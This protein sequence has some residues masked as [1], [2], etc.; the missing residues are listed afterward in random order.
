ME[1]N[2]DEENL[3]EPKIEKEEPTDPTLSKLIIFLIS[4]AIAIV[5][6]LLAS[7]F[8]GSNLMDPRLWLGGFI[9]HMSIFFFYITPIVWK[10]VPITIAFL[11]MTTYL[12]M[13]FNFSLQTATIG[14]F[15][16]DVFLLSL[17]FA[18]A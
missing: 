18:G 8:L 9:V 11:V 14:G 6:V 1:N 17:F 7:L 2:I 13:A 3:V 12:V 15:L 4:G 16:L 5:F 10:V